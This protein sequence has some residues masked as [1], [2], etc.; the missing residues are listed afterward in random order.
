MKHV[1]L[2]NIYISKKSLKTPNGYLEAINRRTENTKEKQRS[3]K[4][5]YTE[6]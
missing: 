4:H 2:S 1:G 6:N 3:I 5:Y